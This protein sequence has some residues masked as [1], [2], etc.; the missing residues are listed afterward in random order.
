MSKNPRPARPFPFDPPE[1]VV[2]VAI[3]FTV[4]TLLVVLFSQQSLYFDAGVRRVDFLGSLA[5]V[6]LV[7]AGL[8]AT[9]YVYRSGRARRTVATLGAGTGVLALGLAILPPLAARS[10]WVTTVLVV[11]VALVGDLVFATWVLGA[12]VYAEL[13]WLAEL[14]SS[15][16]APHSPSNRPMHAHPPRGAGQP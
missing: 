4:V 7:I 15:A 14:E 3:V 2:G 5:G 1:A 11:L 16:A 10:G 9:G 12:A 8:A 6:L 13:P